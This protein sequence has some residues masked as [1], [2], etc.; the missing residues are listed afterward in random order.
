MSSGSLN[1]ANATLYAGKLVINGSTVVPGSATILT[2]DSATSVP[3]QGN[4]AVSVGTVTAT[5]AATDLEFVT[6]AGPPGSLTLK[7]NIQSV[8]AGGGNWSFKGDFVATAG[9]AYALNDVVFDTVN[10]NETYIC[11]LAYTTA[12]GASA[13][14]ANPTNWA[15]FA[16]NSSTGGGIPSL[17][18][19]PATAGTGAVSTAFSATITQNA[20]TA[21]AAFTGSAGAMALAINVPP[22]ASAPGTVIA[23]TNP[24]SATALNWVAGVYQPGV[25]LL[26]TSDTP[27]AVYICSSV[28]TATDGAP[29]TAS[30][31]QWNKLVEQGGGAATL[32][33][34]VQAGAR[35]W[36]ATGTT[37]SPPITALGAGTFVA[38]VSW[39]SSSAGD[40]TG[41][42]SCVNP[43]TGATALQVLATSAVTASATAIYTYQVIQLT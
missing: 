15:L 18:T 16:T 26:D 5:S 36:A 31:A 7:G 32:P 4:V 41:I 34:I 23:G 9:T 24:G 13:P 28:T 2:G 22:S 6:A 29:H 8:G 14:S 3:V 42:L 1:N 19:T 40:V 33:R 43:A 10:V 39:A 12:A 17:T 25:M 30:P 27:P 11:F 20:G 21:T 38:M 35:V 37:D